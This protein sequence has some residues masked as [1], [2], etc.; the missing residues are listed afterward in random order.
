MSRRTVIWRGNRGSVG[1]V[2]LARSTGALLNRRGSVRTL[3][4]RTPTLLVNWGATSPILDE[5]PI[6]YRVLNGRRSVLN[7][8]NKL[9]TAELFGDAPW[10]PR[11]TTHKE[12]AAEWGCAVLCRQV[13]NGHSGAGIV[14][15][16]TPDELVDAPLYVQY[17][18]KADEYRVHVWAGSIHDVTQKKLRS[19]FD[20][21]EVDF[22]VRNY[23]RG[24]IYAREDVR[25]PDAAAQAAVAAVRR[26]GLYFGAVDI[27]W[28]NH[29]SAATVYEV[30]TAPGLYGETTLANYT[31]RIQ[32]EEAFA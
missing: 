5:L 29:Y 14:L 19:G 16:E 7:A 20:P 18:K 31:K 22:Q 8:S 11:S 2:S 13:L 15:A 17:R 21:D 25:L 24:W 6:N 12:V 9:R 26:L 10:A 30:N 23:S 1:A 27:G 32:D 3:Q 4:R 28:N